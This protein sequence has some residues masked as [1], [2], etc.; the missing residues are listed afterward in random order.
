MLIQEVVMRL[1]HL[2]AWVGL[3]GLAIT[4]PTPND[5]GM[6]AAFS[7]IAN[8]QS[9]QPSRL[10]AYTLDEFKGPR[11]EIAL[12]K[13]NGHCYNFESPVYE[14]LQSYMVSNLFCSFI[15]GKDCVGKILVMADAVGTEVWGRVDVGGVSGH[16]RMMRSVHC[17]K[18]VS[19][20]A[21]GKRSEG[22]P[23]HTMEGPGQTIVCEDTLEHGRCVTI[24]A[25]RACVAL[26]PGLA[27]NVKTIYQSAGAVCKYYRTTCSVLTPFLSINSHAK[28]VRLPL[29]D[30]FRGAIGLVRCESSSAVA[31]SES[32]HS[33]SLESSL[34]SPN[35]GQVDTTAPASVMPIRVCHDVN[36]A[37]PC[38]DVYGPGCFNNPFGA[39]AIESYTITPHYRCAFY[40]ASNCDGNAHGP[41]YY[42]DAKDSPKRVDDSDWNIRSASCMVNPLG[43]WW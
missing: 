4:S 23:S 9:S 21:A 35:Q 20:V 8:G 28:A 19:E 43:G 26:P 41:P 42:D 39:D 33:R 2:V 27:H 16:A 32:S 18:S 7:V 13:V 36:M 3:A 22:I 15:D 37:G 34:E 1:S 31:E 24:S 10:V 30:Q 29:E 12:A 38:Y 6:T 40:P 17:N 5:A 25:N 11:Y 14:N